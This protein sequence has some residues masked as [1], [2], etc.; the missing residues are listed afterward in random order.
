LKAGKIENQIAVMMKPAQSRKQPNPLRHMN[1]IFRKAVGIFS[2]LVVLVTSALAGNLLT[3]P[4]FE[5]DPIGQ[6]QTILGWTQYGGNTYSETSLTIAH[7]GTNYFKVY[8]AFNGQVNYTGIYQDYISGPGAVYSADGWAY[9]LS[10][11][12]LAGQNIAWIEVTFRD[13]NTNILALYRSALITTNS[14]ATGAFP[15]NTW[16]DLPVTNQYNLNTSTVTNTS[17]QLVAPAGTYFV[18]YQVVFQG[19][20][21][22]SNG[23]VY[24]DDLNLVQTS[25]AP[26]GNWNIVWSDE[27]N[28]THI[29]PNVWTY[30]IGNGGSNPGWGN[31][32][33]EYY[34][35]RTNNAHVAGGLLHIV[36][37][38]ES[39][40]GFS[41]TSARLKSE[42]LFSWQYGRF[43]WRAQLPSGVG[44]W[45]ALWLL[46][47]NINTIGWPGCGEID[48][49][50]NNGGALTN[51]QG[52]L[53]SGSNE[54][55]IYTLPNGGSVTNFHT[56]TLDWSTNAILFYVDG[57][58]Y[59]TQTRW[60]DSSGTYPFPFNQPFFLIMNLAVGGNY[61]GNPNGSTIFPSEMQVDYVRIYNQTS[62]LRISSTQTNSRILLAWPG[63]IVCHLQVQTNSLGTNWI[64]VVTATNSLQ[65][66][67]D[68]NAAFYR[69]ASP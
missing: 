16:V 54:T 25:G 67:P 65:L 40:D 23:S 50:E 36:A 56:Y 10:G 42:G 11:D 46:G 27:F 22:N 2:C 19:D 26:Y 58:L 57:H 48:M 7:N 33:L 6:N 62:P 34:T 39:Y 4:G 20:A 24:F 1:K 43:E 64:D 38:K 29:N 37:Q 47:T 13:A 21:N 5:S 61:V 9:T 68:N 30:D 60:T 55:Q 14:L 44:F 53:H 41:Y 49:M 45:P 63:N 52:S 12:K 35:S 18:R 17:R 8:Q 66:I 28:G 69:L 31:S 32:E 51:V 15:V 3:N 59:E